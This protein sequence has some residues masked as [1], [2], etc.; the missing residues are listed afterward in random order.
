MKVILGEE[1][2]SKHRLLVRHPSP[3]EVHQGVGLRDPEKQA[4]LSEV[5]KAKAQDSGQKSTVDERW[6]SLLQATQQVCGVSSN[7]PWMKQT[8]WWNNQVDERES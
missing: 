2:A 5:S 7:H 3:N 8:C 4:G 6:T 1:C